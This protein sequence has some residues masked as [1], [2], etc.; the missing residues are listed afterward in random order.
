VAFR[1]E[2]DGETMRSTDVA[3]SEPWSEDALSLSREP[4]AGLLVVGLTEKGKTRGFEAAHALL[5]T[6]TFELPGAGGTPVSF[7]EGHCAVV[8]EDGTEINGVQWIG[9][10]LG[11]R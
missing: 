8:G 6:L 7:L 2:Y 4:H 10:Q 1:L 3:L 9:G 11:P 5:A